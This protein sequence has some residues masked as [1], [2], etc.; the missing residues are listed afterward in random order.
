M[1]GRLAITPKAHAN[2]WRMTRRVAQRSGRDEDQ[3]HDGEGTGDRADG[4]AG[5]AV[6]APVDQE[7]IR[8]RLHHPARQHA[9]AHPDDAKRRRQA[10]EAPTMTPSDGGDPDA[11]ARLQGRVQDVGVGAHTAP[12]ATVATTMKQIVQNP[13]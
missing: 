2:Q 1:S 11:Q 9:E 3:Q 7:R 5:G 8:D 12:S 10:M 13:A 4:H 6:Q